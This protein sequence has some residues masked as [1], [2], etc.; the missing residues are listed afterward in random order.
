MATI[1]KADGSE[2]NLV[3]EKTTSLKTLQ[4]A[5]GGY[6]ELLHTK[7]GRYMLCNEDGKSMNLS[8]NEK[9][10]ELWAGQNEIILGDVVVCDRIEL[11]KGEGDE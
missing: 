4:K 5:V 2:E 7:D 11:D 1:I 3:L 9:A 6:I 8:P 10:T